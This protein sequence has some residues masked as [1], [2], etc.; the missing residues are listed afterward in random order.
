MSHRWTEEQED[1]AAEQETRQKTER[2]RMYK[3]LLHN[4]NYTTMDFVV[5][6]LVDVF[7]KPEAEAVVIM[8]DVHQKGIGVAGVYVREIA[9]TKVQRA[10]QLARQAEFPLLCTMEPE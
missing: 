6:V 4:D 10:M 7:H 3:V 5:M 2:P 1:V 8:L 9:E